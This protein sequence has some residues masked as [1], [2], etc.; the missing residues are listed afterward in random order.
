L[1]L[2]QRVGLES[3]A[4]GL[5]PIPVRGSSGSPAIVRAQLSSLALRS[6]LRFFEGLSKPDLDT[7]LAAASHRRFSSNSVVVRQRDPA[8]RLYLLIRGS[9]RYF[10]ITAD[11]RK[12]YLL[13]L[14]AGE[15]FG[16]A[17]LLNY[18]VTYLL[19]TEVARESQVLVWRR[20]IIRKLAAQF[21]RLLENGFSIAY[22]YLAWYVATHLSLVSYSARK[23]LAHVLLTLSDG[24]GRKSPTGVQLDITNEQLANTA[25]I[26]LF[27]ASRL[28][29]EWQRNGAITKSRGKILIRHP[30]RIFAATAHTAR[31]GVR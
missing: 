27:T 7:I 17:A 19:N 13:W 10:F 12:V 31:L 1:E 9:A 11:G 5:L 26:T 8:D 20:D 4:V 2:R 21:P 15:M 24:I 28:L 30:E 14:A 29:S 16:G 6:K 22:D 18:P 23:R 3:N 25:N